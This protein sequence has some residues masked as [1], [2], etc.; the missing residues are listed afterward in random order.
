MTKVR[1]RLLLSLSLIWNNTCLDSGDIAFVTYEKGEAEAKIRFKKGDA[2]KP[3]S[4][5]WTEAVNIKDHKVQCNIL[6]VK[7]FLTFLSNVVFVLPEVFAL[8]TSQ[9]KY[10]DP[11]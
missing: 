6:E 11:R 2:A 1:N 7:Y 9:T 3:V 10:L 4:E 8:C 5:K